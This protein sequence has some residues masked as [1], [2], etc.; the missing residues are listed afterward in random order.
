M[1]SIA[2]T[3]TCAICRWSFFFI[4]FFNL[5]FCHQRA[6]G[7]V[8]TGLN[9]HHSRSSRSTRSKTHS[10]HQL[11]L[12]VAWQ[13]GD[14][15]YWLG[16][17]SSAPSVIER[18]K[19]RVHTQKKKSVGRWLSRGGSGRTGEVVRIKGGVRSFF[20]V[21]TRVV[22]EQTRRRGGARCNQKGA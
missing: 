6:P 20:F 5:L 3:Q 10:S 19:K 16:C 14:Q 17:N 22:R 7:V 13:L 1:Y 12:Y 4:S 2:S 11:D 8:L 18:K 21:Y 9:E 15:L